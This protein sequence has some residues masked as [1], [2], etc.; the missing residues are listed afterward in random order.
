[1]LWVSINLYI[2]YGISFDIFIVFQNSEKGSLGRAG[3]LPVG[4]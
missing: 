4:Q 3:I 2:D 1:M